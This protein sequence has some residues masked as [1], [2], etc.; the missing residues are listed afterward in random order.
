MKKNVL[1]LLLILMGLFTLQAQQTKSPKLFVGIVVDQMREEYLTRFYDQYGEEGFKKLMKDGFNCRNM[2][3]NYVPTITGPGHTSIYAGTTPSIHGIIAN[4]WY[5]RK[6]RKSIYCVD[7]TAER[8]LG[9]ENSKKGSSPHNLLVTN[10]CDELKIATNQHAKVI[11]ISLKDRAAILPAGHMADGA[12]WLDLKSG[13]FV[14]STFYMKS[15]PEWVN[16]F[17]AEK[18][19][20]K[21]L[22]KP[23]DLLLPAE[24]YPNSLPDDNPYESCWKGKSQ[25]TFPYDLK[26]LSAFNPPT[27]GMLYASPYGN[28]LLTDFAIETIKKENLGKG[29]YTDMLT[30]SYS[31]TDA[32]G[33]KFGPLSKEINDTY[34]RLDL[35]I[36]RLIASL[37]QLVGKGNYTLFLTADHGVAEVPQY[38]IDHKTPAGY[39]TE[40]SVKILSDQ[41]LSSVLGPG[42]WITTLTNSQIYLNKAMIIA[43]GLKVTDVEERLADFL[44]DMNGIAKVFTAKQL[45]EQDFVQR[46]PHLVQNGFNFQRSG[47]VV[48]VLAPNWTDNESHKG[49]THSSAYTYDT[50][51]PMLWYGWGISKGESLQHHNITDVAPT[52]SGLLHIKFPS[53]CTGDPIEEVLLKK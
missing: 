25:P 2:H 32:I 51:V 18:L 4:D 41:F 36:A 27:Y 28:S 40:D 43:K 8:I 52:I 30:I 16:A 50:H 23:W 14:S 7:D 47:D 24:K 13:N 15:L 17:N 5:D 37:D 19:C 48:Y 6:I 34:L 31:S 35:E 9:I 38:L 3:Y 45:D 22:E 21:Y 1:L 20:A 29:N 46:I 12:Y 26:A 44:K 33:H 49:T 39:L 42:N 10:I 53:G 11:G